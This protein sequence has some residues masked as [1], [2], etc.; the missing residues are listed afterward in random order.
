[1]ASDSDG[2]VETVQ[3]L[4]AT[5]VFHFLLLLPGFLTGDLR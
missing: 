4:E 5:H 3:A 1:M 2:L